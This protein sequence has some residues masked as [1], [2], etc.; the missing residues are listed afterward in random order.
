MTYDEILTTVMG[1]SPGQ[2]H[3][4]NDGPTYLH[5]T[6]GKYVRGHHSRAAYRTDVSLGLA[7]GLS[8]PDD[9]RTFVW[10]ERFADQRA[11]PEF[12]DILWNGMLIHRE[13]GIVIDGGRA[14]LPWPRGEYI[15]GESVMDYEHITDSFTSRG[16]KLWR[17]VA[18]LNSEK[19]EYDRYVEQSGVVILPDPEPEP[20]EPG[21]SRDW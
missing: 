13:Y 3:V 11:Y 18:Y 19:N 8:Y 20:P 15:R 6:G 12:L 10:T 9:Q 14:V 17:L 21:P 1:S 5:D 16:V 7:W 4:V 2:W